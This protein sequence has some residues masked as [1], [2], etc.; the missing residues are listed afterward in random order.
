MSEKVKNLEVL[1]NELMEMDRGLQMLESKV[2]AKP[3]LKEL[4]GIVEL[5]MNYG[6]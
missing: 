4:E 3:T 2:R 6:N 1:R 5:T